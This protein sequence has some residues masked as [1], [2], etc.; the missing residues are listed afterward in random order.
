MKISKIVFVE[1]NPTGKPFQ[2]EEQI[3]QEYPP[4]AIPVRGD[5]V[6]LDSGKGDEQFTFIVDSREFVEDR[7]TL[8]Y[9]VRYGIRR[10]ATA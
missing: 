2:K 9:E 3:S 4:P 5:V 7:E 10:Q 1:V 8:S 6:S